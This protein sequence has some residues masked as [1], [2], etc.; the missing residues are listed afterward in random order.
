MEL[1]PADRRPP[2]SEL[3]GPRDV[4]RALAPFVAG[5]VEGLAVFDDNGPVHAAVS[6]P[7]GAITRWETLPAEAIAALRA[8]GERSFGLDGLRCDVRPLFAGADRVAILIVACR[9]D[10]GGAVEARLAD[11]IGGVGGLLAQLFQAS[12]AAWVT[13]QMHLA[14]A[15]Q[16]H[17]AVT[18]RN[19]ELERAVDHLRHL[20]KLKS[21]FLATVSHEL[22]TPLTSVIGFSEMLL[23]GMAGAL[24]PEQRDYVE[25]IF[26]R[27]EE[28]LSLIT[29][30]LELSQLEGGSVRLSLAACSVEWMVLR[31]VD[32]VALAAEQEGLTIVAEP[33]SVGAVVADADKV[34]RV[35]LNLLGNAIK[36]TP[37]GGRITV[38]AQPAP[39]RRPFQEETLFGEE[40]PDAVRITVADTGIGI[41]PE[42]LSRI[43]EAFYQV[44][45][46]PTRAH[47]GAGLGLSIVHSLVAGHGGDVWVDSEPDRGTAIHFT[48]PLASAEALAQIP[49]DPT[50][51]D[52]SG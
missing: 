38:T 46:G 3:I 43:F 27:G 1:T 4:E 31:A 22:R 13:S 23:E 33:T 51:D 19:E 10:G 17:V 11:A 37:K 15:E 52:A 24:N 20:D 29:H 25:T 18:E 21:N 2:L 5:A 16:A 42:Q 47:G 14:S 45:A 30:L 6:R 44:D 28:L 8:G 12:F 41:A 32:T 35:L 40:M 49:E 34:H 9:A 36:F 39:I 50:A 7:G 48:L 26:G